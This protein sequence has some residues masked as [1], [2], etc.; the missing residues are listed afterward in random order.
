MLWDY[1]KLL[2]ATTAEAYLALFK[3]DVRLWEMFFLRRRFI[4]LGGVLLAPKGGMLD[5]LRVHEGAHRQRQHCVGIWKWYLLY[6]ISRRFRMQEECFAYFWEMSFRC[7]HNGCHPAL[8]EP[9]FAKILS[10]VAYLWIMSEQEVKAEI[11]GMRW[12]IQNST[13]RYKRYR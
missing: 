11:A 7:L 3:R 10:G 4:L 13:D 2:K 5:C 9:V 1:V 8:M 12:A 6:I